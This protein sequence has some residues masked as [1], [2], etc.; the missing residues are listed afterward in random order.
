MIIDT[1]ANVG[2][3][4]YD[5]ARFEFD[6]SLETL[7]R[8]LADA[9]I[10]K[11]IVAPLKP[12]QYEFNEVNEQ[13]SERLAG[14]DNFYGIGRIDP[15]QDDAAEKADRA[16]NEYN[17]HGLKLHPWEE[18]FEITSSFVTPALETAATYDVPVWIHS[19]YYGVSN[20]LSV[21]EVAHSFPKL[22]MVVT[23]GGHLNISGLSLPDATKLRDETENTY[24][25]LSGVYRHDFIQQSFDK[26]GA[27]RILFGT[28]APYFNPKVELSRIVDADIT[29][30]EKETALSET[31][32][33]LL[34]ID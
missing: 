28:N 9:G 6:P 25:E 23:H 31:A 10:D 19:G 1:N 26:I 18:T 14:R 12:P 8:R 30:D 33:S 17:L 13:L 11:A 15:R 3:T 22:P 2:P 20:A 5:D 7:E 34:N 24:F 29:S 27:E 16:L 32:L 4:I 21:R